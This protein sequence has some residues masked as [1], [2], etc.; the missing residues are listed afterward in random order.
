MLAGSVLLSLMLRSAAPKS[1]WKRSRTQVFRCR[2][3]IPAATTSNSHANN[4][5]FPRLVAALTVI[6]SHSFLIAEE[7]PVARAAGLA[8]RITSARQP[9]RRS[10]L[11]RDQR[12]SHYRELLP[13]GR[14]PAGFVLR[15]HCG[16][17]PGPMVNGLVC[18]F[19]LGPIVTSLALSAYLAD[20][21][22]AR[23]PR[24]IRD[25]VARPARAP[26]RAFRQHHRGPFDQRLVLDA[27]L[28]SLHV[29]DGP[30]SRGRAP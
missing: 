17:Y 9:R 20:H 15:L 13:R 5:D 21:G 2:P 29:P 8:Q 28:R 30:G 7:H 4:F 6:F 26:W 18:A 11:L 27:A 23:F 1:G 24:R 14:K 19:V 3:P 12:L 25:A 16:I 10:H 22:A